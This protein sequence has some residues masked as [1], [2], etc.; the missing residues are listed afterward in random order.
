MGEPRFQ[1]PEMIFVLNTSKCIISVLDNN[2]QT[3]KLTISQLNYL[4]VEKV[5][6]TTETNKKR[7]GAFYTPKVLTDLICDW[8]ITSIN[9]RVLEPSFEY[10]W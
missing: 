9:T 5:P 7:L 3:S 10:V 4:N 6:V 2:V 8:A 1:W